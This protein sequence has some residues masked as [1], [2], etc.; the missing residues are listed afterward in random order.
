MEKLVEATLTKPTL[1]SPTG[2]YEVSEDQEIPDPDNQRQKLTVKKQVK[3]QRSKYSLA[4]KM[5][6]NVYM[7]H[8][9]NWI[10]ESCHWK[11]NRSRLYALILMH[12]P[13]DLEEI[14][15]TMSPWTALSDGYDAT[16]LLKMVCDVAHIQTEVN[17]TVMGFVESMTKLFAHHK[18]NK[19]SDDDYSI[20]FNATVESIKVHGGQP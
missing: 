1:P 10:E 13:Q 5:E 15:K 14:L 2:E 7:L 20:I 6:M 12:C 9:K 17:Q 8:Y 19:L 11:T 4:L 18:D 16:Q 3:K